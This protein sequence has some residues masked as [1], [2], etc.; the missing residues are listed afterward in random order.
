V[1]FRP[2]VYRRAVSL[3]LAGWVQ[4]DPAGVAIEAEGEI[5]ALRKLLGMKE[6]DAFAIIACPKENA[7]QA[8]KMFELRA[9]YA[10]EGVPLE[11][12]GVADT[13]LCT[14][15]VLRPLPSGSRMYPETD[16]RP[17]TITKAML[18][19]A[20]IAAPD[21]ENERK[22]LVKSIG[23]RLT[24]Q[25]LT[26]QSLSMFKRI[27]NETKVQPD[28][29]ANILLQKFVELRR[30]GFDAYSI[31][32]DRLEEIFRLYEKKEITKQGIEELL[33]AASTDQSEIVKIVK[34]KALARVTGSALEKMIREIKSERKPASADMLRKIVMEKHRLVIDGEELNAVISKI[35]K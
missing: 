8:L 31:G 16:I 18:K 27:T 30:N 34:K 1:G 12:R 35:Y 9:G 6:Q 10:I 19:E 22:A 14:T 7:A 23:E 17:I 25:M 2:F 24:E 5:A 4:N 32:A 21:I 28:F 13:E 15:K 33:K 20:Q 29:V 26:S 11:T 3:G